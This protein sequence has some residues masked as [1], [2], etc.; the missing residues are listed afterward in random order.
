[1]A[2]LNYKTPI[3]LVPTI[4][5]GVGALTYGVKSFFASSPTSST[6]SSISSKTNYSTSPSPVVNN[7]PEVSYDSPNSD[8]ANFINPISSSYS[9][10]EGGSRKKKKRKSKPKPKSKT[11]SKSKSR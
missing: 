6:P 3:I 9:S 2:N 8:G 5:L 11:K 7:S 4:L 10:S 1:M